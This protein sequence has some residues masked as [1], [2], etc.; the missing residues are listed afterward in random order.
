M[1]EGKNHT[2]YLHS[3]FPQLIDQ[4]PR[5]DEE[6]SKA[7]ADDAI[8]LIEKLEKLRGKEFTDDE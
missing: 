3:D 8:K 4:I 5:H 6:L 7:Y 1:K 2:T